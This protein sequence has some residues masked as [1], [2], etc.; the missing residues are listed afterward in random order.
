MNNL[1]QRILTG[2][3]GAAIVIGLVWFNEWT[4]FGLFLLI[5][6]LC[7]WELYGMFV[8]NGKCPQR[9]L[10]LLTGICI[11]VT[12]FLQQ[13]DATDYEFLL[14]NLIPLFLIFITEL[15]RKKGTTTENL[16]LTFLGIIYAAL[17]FALLH[18]IAF[19]ET[20]NYQREIILG[21]LFLQWACDT[22]AYF[23]GKYFGK[24]KLWERISP[25]K[26]WE[27]S[28]GGLVACIAVS[29]ALAKNYNS[30]TQQNWLALS[31]IIGVISQFGD[32]TESAMKRNFQIKDSGGILPGHG[33]LLDR[34]DGL[35]LAIPFVAV[36][37]GFWR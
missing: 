16:S 5:S 32:L 28:I 29:F 4:Y 7:Q 36:Y 14:V 9:F 10:G 12:V 3:L 23:V 25:K 30:L 15:F 1:L 35:I 2:I 11:N 8:K 37:F 21:I 33:G 26:T 13:R 19:D 18:L 20:L 22:G 17:P 31:L 34:F 27:G 6:F 24:R